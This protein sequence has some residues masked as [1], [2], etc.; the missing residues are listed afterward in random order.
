MGAG[1]CEKKTLRGNVP[2][3]HGG[4]RRVEGRSLHCWEL[5]KRQGCLYYGDGGGIRNVGLGSR[6]FGPIFAERRAVIR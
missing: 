1:N 2:L 4:R 3:G 5:R 6:G